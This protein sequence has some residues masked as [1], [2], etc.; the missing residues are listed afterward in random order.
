MKRTAEMALANLEMRIAKLEKAKYQKWIDVEFEKKKK[1]RHIK[2]QTELKAMASQ[3]NSWYD[4]EQDL[5]GRDLKSIETSLSRPLGRII[6]VLQRS[7]LA[8]RVDLGTVTNLVK[9]SGSEE[10]TL[11]F[12]SFYLRLY[13]SPFDAWHDPNSVEVKFLTNQ[14]RFYGEADPNLNHSF[15]WLHKKQEWKIAYNPIRGTLSS[16]IPLLLKARF[17]KALSEHLKEFKKNQELLL[18]ATHKAIASWS[19]DFIKGYGVENFDGLVEDYA[20]ITRR[21]PYEDED[22]HEHGGRESAKEAVWEEV[23][24]VAKKVSGLEEDPKR[25]IFLFLLDF[26][27]DNLMPNVKNSVALVKWDFTMSED[28]YSY[29]TGGDAKWGTMKEIRSLYNK[30]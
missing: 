16:N 11:T 9:E 5:S 24:L 26:D 7:G 23:V 14:R 28:S 20:E 17:A 29:D 13:P 30:S 1:K 19:E 15:E 10:V 18:K 21:R 27:P 4:P 8:F 2:D 25:P 6:K 12:K 22:W 3:L